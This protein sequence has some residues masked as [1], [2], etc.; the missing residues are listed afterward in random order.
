[1]PINYKEYH[2]KWTLIR[3]LI[4]QRADNCCEGSPKF[5]LCRAANN[6]PHPETGSKV[7]LTIAHLNHDKNDNR[8][9]N[10][11]ALCQRCHLHYDIGHHIFNRKYGR[12]TKKLNGKLF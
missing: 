7:I 9:S 11:K 12:D 4:L 1:M 10:L 6:Q 3:R 8:F 2:P 5:H